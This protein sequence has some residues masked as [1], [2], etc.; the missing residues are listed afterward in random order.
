LLRL[1]PIDRIDTDTRRNRG[2]NVKCAVRRLNESAAGAFGVQQD[3]RV[4]E[5]FVVGRQ[6]RARGDDDARAARNVA[7]L[8]PSGRTV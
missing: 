3:L 1:R 4:L 2:R 7:G 5:P 6:R 8:L